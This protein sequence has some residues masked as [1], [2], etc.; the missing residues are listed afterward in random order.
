VISITSAQRIERHNPDMSRSPSNRAKVMGIVNLTPDSFSDGGRLSSVEQ[1]LRHCERLLKDGADI[2]DLGAESSRPGAA[3]VDEA[4]ELARL[5]P[6][7]AE[8]VKLGV[9]ISVDTYKPA[10]M[11]AVL[12]AGA[13]II[14]DIYALQ[15]SP[16][17]AA[18]NPVQPRDLTSQ[19]PA[20][21]V[22]AGHPQCQVC[23]MHMHG[24]PQTMKQQ[25]MHGDPVPQLLF[26]WE[27]A[28]ANFLGNG[29]QKSQ[30]ILDPGIGFGKTVPQ[31]FELLRRQSEL[32]L[33]GLPLLVGWSRKSSLAFAVSTSLSTVANLDP[34]DRLVP[35]VTAALLAVQGGASIVRVHDVRETVQALRVYNAMNS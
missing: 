32:L 26:F 24:T 30:I 5:M 34:R 23:L 16:A 28:M 35:S 12:G 31:N 29:G 8:A 27:L 25:P 11:Q 18:A 21:K 22:V 6:V 7:L 20:L 3:Y 4:E 13:A 2:L 15:W 19:A 1:A 33:P 9:P 10:V 17:A 14:N